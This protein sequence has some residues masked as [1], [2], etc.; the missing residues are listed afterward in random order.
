LSGS[1]VDLSCSVVVLV[2]L[3]DEFGSVCFSGALGCSFT[4]SLS[5]SPTEYIIEAFLL[6]ENTL[7]SILVLF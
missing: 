2:I 3:L 7:Q 5:I 6:I 1:E 4:G